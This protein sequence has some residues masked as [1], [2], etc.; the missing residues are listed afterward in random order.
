MDL[1]D[2]D[3]KEN[4]DAAA[5]RKAQPLIVWT[6]DTAVVLGAQPS[7]GTRDALEF[8]LRRPQTRAAEFVAERVG[9]DHRQCQHEV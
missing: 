1:S 8:A 2:P 4:Y 5:A 9:H 7:Q 3:V 6:G